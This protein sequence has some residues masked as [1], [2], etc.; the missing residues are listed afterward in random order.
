LPSPRWS[1]QTTRYSEPFNATPTLVCGEAGLVTSGASRASSG[2]SSSLL[3]ARGTIREGGSY[4]DQPTKP[5]PACRVRR[6]DTNLSG[7]PGGTVL[8]ES[9]P[10]ATDLREEGFWPSNQLG[11]T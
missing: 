11:A 3:C 5:S 10:K 6:T 9:S 4:G 8:W 1:P 7:R 2:D